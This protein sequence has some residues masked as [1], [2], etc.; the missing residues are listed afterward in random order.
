MQNI[1]ASI[2]PII[3]SSGE[4]V[5]YVGDQATVTCT[6]SLEYATVHWML[7][8]TQYDHSQPDIE[9]I[10]L[11]TVSVITINN[12][13]QDYNNSAIRC[14]GS[15]TNGQSFSSAEVTILLQGGSE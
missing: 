14:A 6:G 2:A 3:S 8:N 15:Y 5:H 9:I 12:I 10:N 4:S 13:S 7:N 1:C 11:R